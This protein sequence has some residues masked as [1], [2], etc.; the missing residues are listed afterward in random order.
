MR[1]FAMDDADLLEVAAQRLDLAAQLT[2]IRVPGVGRNRSDPRTWFGSPRVSTEFRP[3]KISA[4]G[5]SSEQYSMNNADTPD[6]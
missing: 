2:F 4:P 5:V 1:L 6:P 3:K